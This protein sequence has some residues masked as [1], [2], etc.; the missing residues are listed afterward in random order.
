MSNQN[1]TICTDPVN[2]I[3]QIPKVDQVIYYRFE[4]DFTDMENIGKTFLTIK[5]NVI[6]ILFAFQSDIEYQ[7]FSFYGYFTI[8]E[9]GI[10]FAIPKADNNDDADICNLFA[11][12]FTKNIKSYSEAGLSTITNT[13]TKFPLFCKDGNKII[14]FYPNQFPPFPCKEIQNGTCQLK[15]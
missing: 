14:T 5:A 11:G 12:A 9:S 8:K 15:N 4:T 3:Y 7:K 6:K 1:H 13:D 2:N 10:I